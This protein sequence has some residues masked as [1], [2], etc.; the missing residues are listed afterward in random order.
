MSLYS[1][2]RILILDPD[3]GYQHPKSISLAVI[4]RECGPSLSV[5]FYSLS[6]CQPAGL[7]GVWGFLGTSF[8]T[9]RA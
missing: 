5:C 3:Y 9:D 1:V 2:M 8:Q 4:G 7:L 6:V